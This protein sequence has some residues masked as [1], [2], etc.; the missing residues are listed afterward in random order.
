[1]AAI[2]PPPALFADPPWVSK[3]C[4]FSVSLSQW[5]ST[6]RARAENTFVEERLGAVDV[7][8]ALGHALVELFLVRA[9][10]VI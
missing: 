4:T 5:E 9:V 6:E 1:M 2:N 3:V 8:G 10:E 7:I